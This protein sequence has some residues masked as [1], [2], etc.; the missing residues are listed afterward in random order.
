MISVF[1]LLVI[2][3]TS[4]GFANGLP[5]A[6]FQGLDVAVISVALPMVGMIL[7]AA[8]LLGLPRKPAEAAKP[9]VIEGAINPPMSEEGKK[10]VSLAQVLN[11][12]LDKPQTPH[13]AGRFL[14]TGMIARHESRK[15]SLWA[16]SSAAD[17]SARYFVSTRSHTSS[18]VS[19]VLSV[20]L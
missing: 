14:R 13:L 4:V 5:L 16:V 18:M 1:G 6:Y 15:A 20:P 17:G 10:E 3:M 11:Q 12:R 19:P 7:F 9:A 2:L 8:I